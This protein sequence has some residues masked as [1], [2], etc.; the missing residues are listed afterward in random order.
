MAIRKLL[1]AINIY[2]A[3]TSFIIPSDLVWPVGPLHI[4]SSLHLHCV[5]HRAP[6]LLSQ[7]SQLIALNKHGTVRLANLHGLGIFV[8][9][10]L[11]NQSLLANL[12][13]HKPRGRLTPLCKYFRFPHGNKY[14][15]KS[16]AKAITLAKIRL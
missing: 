16:R 14:T 4:A 13:G 3:F 15:Y 8:A 2:L 1:L 10:S 5:Y 6:L 7:P 11:L 9:A 12:F